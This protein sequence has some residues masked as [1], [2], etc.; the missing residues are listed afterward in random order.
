MYDTD[1][2]VPSLAIGLEVVGWVT[3]FGV[4]ISI[5]SAYLR[6]HLEDE[7]HRELKHGGSELV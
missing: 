7:R 3:A 1:P 2:F 4:A 5:V 6:R